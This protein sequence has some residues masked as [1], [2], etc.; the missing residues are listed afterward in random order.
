MLGGSTGLN[1]GFPPGS[2]HERPEAGAGL[3][4]VTLTETA[5]ISLLD[6][7]QGGVFLKTDLTKK[8][9]F[10]NVRPAYDPAGLETGA[11][12]FSCYLPT[13]ELQKACHPQREGCHLEP[14]ATETGERTWNVP[15]RTTSVRS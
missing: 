2:G 3:G 7:D 14:D 10:A 8:F 4:A 9:T 11:V 13:A 1:H 6:M 12:P 5:D 15:R